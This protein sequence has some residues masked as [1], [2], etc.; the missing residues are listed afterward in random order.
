MK[1]RLSDRFVETVAWPASGRDVY[2]DERSPGLELRVSVE[3]G[4][5]WSIR[6]RPKGGERQRETYGRYPG[7]TLAAARERAKDIAAAAAKGINLPAQE[8]R[9]R[10]AERQAANRPQTLGDLLDE[11]VEKHCKV[12]QRSWLMVERMFNS[13]VKPA[14]GKTPL[15]DLRRADVVE[16]LDDLQNGKGFRA[17]VNRVRTQIVAALNWAVERE[18][19]DAN[20]AAAVKR[21]KLEASRDRVLTD[22]E[23][24]A[25]W[26][27]ADRLTVPARA[28]VRALILTGQRRDEVRAMRW[29]EVDFDRAVWLLPG[30]RNKSKRDHEVPLSPATVELLN[31]LRRGSKKDPVFTAD[32]TRPYT[33]HQP[34]KV[35]LDRASG[36][37]GW[38]YHDVRRTVATG[39]AALHLPQ[40]TIERILNHA[41]PT[42]VATYNRHHHLDQKRAALEAWAQ[43]VAFIVGESREAENVVELRGTA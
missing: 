34:A 25:I 18:Y 1:K 9:Q 32:G 21:R 39:M 23:L 4:K 5:S 15:G 29:A 31:G 28:F 11:Y 43:R 8:K 16:L 36:T 37:A 27:A 20:P 2:I 12:T 42:L 41:R 10:E 17:Q 6:Y 22:D 30:N 3:G 26:H 35:V 13:H 40:D 7:V 14:I 24:R 38:T 33:G 19:L